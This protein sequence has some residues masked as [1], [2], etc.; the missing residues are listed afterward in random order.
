MLSTSILSVRSSDQAKHRKIHVFC[1]CTTYEPCLDYYQSSDFTQACLRPGKSSGYLHSAMS[2]YLCLQNQQAADAAG[3]CS[4]DCCRVEE[5]GR[6]RHRHPRRRWMR[7]P[8]WTQ[9]QRGRSSST[10]AVDGNG[11][12]MDA[13]CGRNWRGN[14]GWGRR[15]FGGGGVPSSE[16]T[17]TR[18]DWGGGGANGLGVVAAFN[19][20]CLG[21]GDASSEVVAATRVRRLRR[22]HKR[23]GGGGGA[24]GL[25]MAATDGS[26]NCSS[27]VHLIYL[28][29]FTKFRLS[30][31]LGQTILVMF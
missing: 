16:A 6:R 9:R 5:A 18:K 8:V 21:G 19:W 11:P 29:I 2:I 15:E 31:L 4:V 23:T 7:S 27:L 1:R 12:S 26:T 22:R 24:S 25:G 30:G 13:V 20:A 17:A 14:R 3:V 28:F 10:A